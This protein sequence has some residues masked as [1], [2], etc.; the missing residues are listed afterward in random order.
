MAIYVTVC[1]LEKYKGL[2]G[3][4]WMKI[5]MFEWNVTGKYKKVGPWQN[6]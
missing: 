4:E 1:H 3:G 2:V 6:S 5:G